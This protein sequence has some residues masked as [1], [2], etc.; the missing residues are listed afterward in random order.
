MLLWIR[1]S[2]RTPF[3]L[4]S[5]LFFAAVPFVLSLWLFRHTPRRGWLWWPLFAVFIVFLPNAAYTLTDV[6]HFVSDVRVND[7]Q[8]P[9]WAVACIVIPKYA[10]FMFLGFQCHVISL[11]RVVKY[12]QWMSRRSWTLAVELL[13]NFLCSVG[14]Y[15][16]RYIRLSSWDIVVKPDEIVQRTLET[17]VPNEFAKMVIGVYFVIITTL[18]FVFKFVDLAIWEHWRRIWAR[19]PSQSQFST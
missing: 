3:D 19:G 9:T 15:W 7:P 10:A 13:L 5:N 2:L 14:V 17:L 18:Y 8:I 4:G 1:M 11:I 16:G 6:I 12:L